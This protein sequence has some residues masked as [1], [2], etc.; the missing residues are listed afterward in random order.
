MLVPGSIRRVHGIVERGNCERGPVHRRRGGNRRRQRFDDMVRLLGRA[1]HETGQ[2][3]G[4]QKLARDAPNK[5]DRSITEPNK[6]RE[7]L[8]ERRRPNDYARAG[9]RTPVWTR[10]ADRARG[11]DMPEHELVPARLSSRS[12]RWPFASCCCLFAAGRYISMFPQ[13]LSAG[14]CTAAGTNH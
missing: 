1:G 7:M 10:M 4:I 12:C 6:R 3:S 5:I 11:L 9:G 8:S 2:W 13:A 14:N